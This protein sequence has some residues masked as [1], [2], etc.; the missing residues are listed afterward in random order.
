MRKTRIIFLIFFIFFLTASVCGYVWLKLKFKK[1]ASFPKE[2]CKIIS[3]FKGIH[4]LGKTE[5]GE[6][7]NEM[8]MKYDKEGNVFLRKVI[9]SGNSATIQIIKQEDGEGL[10]Y[11]YTYPHS[12]K[13]GQKLIGNPKMKLKMSGNQ[14]ICSDLLAFINS[15][16]IGITGEAEMLRR[17]KIKI[18]VDPELLKLA[19]HFSFKKPQENY[20][21]DVLFEPPAD[22]KW[23]VISEKEGKERNKECIDYLDKKIKEIAERVLG[24]ENKS[25][26]EKELI[27]KDAKFRECLELQ[28]N[29]FVPFY[30]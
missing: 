12:Q 27:E 2:N 29:L 5:N 11:I 13:L 22:Y 20:I 18:E 10:Q 17:E 15:Q 9:Y 3:L 28:K 19:K 7:V 16:L 1:I 8:W 4:L 6:L 21:P 30:R 25:E 24:G 23:V 14:P 26:I